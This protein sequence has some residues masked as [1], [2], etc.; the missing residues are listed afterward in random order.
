MTSMFKGISKI[1]GGVVIVLFILLVSWTAYQQKLQ[2]QQLQVIPVD[3]D[4]GCDLRAGPCV[5]ALKDGASV[6]FSIEPREIPLA[7][8][9]QLMVHVEGFKVDGV[10]VEL[11]GVDMKMPLNQLELENTVKGEFSAT[12]TLSFCSR[13]AMEWEALLEL[14]SGNKRIKVPYRFITVSQPG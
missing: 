5:I 14:R 7:R 3:Y 1:Q 10:S 8:P 6:S 13:N 12:A 4:A 11:N 2:S 9:L